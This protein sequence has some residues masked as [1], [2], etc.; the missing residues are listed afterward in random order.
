MRRV[1]EIDRSR[2]GYLVH[3]ATS[4]G[5][6]VEV[7]AYI[8]G[9]EDPRYAIESRVLCRTAEQAAEIARVLREAMVQT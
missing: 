7:V 9:L 8:E 5:R 6:H 2:A 3:S 1:T 4:S